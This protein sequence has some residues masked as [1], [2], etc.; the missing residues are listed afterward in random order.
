MSAPTHYATHANIAVITMD[1][2]PV[3]GLGHALR[4][5]LLDDFERALADDGIAAIVI[6]SAGKLFCGGADIS[7][8]GGDSALREPNLPQVLNRLE[9]S[10]KPV[11][12]AV[13]GMALGGGMELALVCDYRFAGAAA[14]F[15]LPEVNLG[16]LPGAGGTQRLPR[17][18]G[19]P[20]ALEMIT[21]GRPISV[22]KAQQAG[23]VDRRHN[24]TGEFLDAAITYAA[25][26]VDSGAS[27]HSC[28]TLSV[29]TTDL[30]DNFFADFRRSIARRTRGL[31]APERCIQAVEAACTLPLAEGLQREGELFIE[32][33]NTPQARAQQHLFFAERAATKVPGV[34][35][36]TPVRNIEKVAVIGSGTMG[37]GIAMNFLNAGI[38]V[39]VLDLNAEALERGAEVIRNNYAITAKKGKLTEAQVEQRMELLT[40]TT[41]YASIAGVDLVIEAVFENMDIKKK[42]FTTLDEVCKPGA[43]LATNTSTLDVDEIAAVTKRPQD[44]IGLHF[45]SPANVMRLLE[46]VRGK[47][48]ADDVIVTSIKMAQAIKKIP[49]VVGVCFG[50]VG[51]RMLEPY[52]RE[53]SRLLLEGATPA[54]VDRV[55]YDFGLA[56]GIFSMGDLAGIDVSFLVREGIRDQIAHDPGYQKISDK[57]YALGRYGQ[58]TGRGF[59]IY[60]GRERQED[61]EVVTLAEEI[62]AELGIERRE[63]S[64]QEIL[65]RTIY[66]LI[67]E[68]AQI[69][70]EGIAYRSS[71]CD[72]V[73]CNGYGFPIGRGG[74]MQ[75]ADEIGLDTVLA[76]IEKYR[77]QLGAYGEMWFKPAPL[78]QRLVKEGK[79]FKQYT[80]KS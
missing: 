36:K 14:R 76:A 75:Y 30:P 54:Q 44:V 8:F 38:P 25:E 71:D 2:P 49:V 35:P 11:V 15:G 65:E 26:L 20:L 5:S 17:L 13:N 48:T 69:L 24:D 41:E 4:R 59:Y 6:A 32:C 40:T 78:L 66:M 3:N 1:S 7:E 28:A 19:V 74:P 55:L 22:D 12:A 77:Q 45:F 50:F 16:I 18:A 29:D 31:Y 43:I 39:T 67:N 42:V 60:E 46:I 51:N 72:I 34:D 52:S 70:D 33:M 9:E 23:L 62:A 27:V 61:P 68:G 64:D 21:S 53:A 63:I 79:Q 57:L 47:A 73:Y 58:K 10:P 56:M 37:G 80:V